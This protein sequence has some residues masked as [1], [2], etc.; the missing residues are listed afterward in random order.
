[1]EG[2]RRFFDYK[3]RRHR[4]TIDFELFTGKDK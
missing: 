2:G 1:M 3:M 4:G